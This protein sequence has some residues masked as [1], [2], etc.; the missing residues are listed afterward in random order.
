MSWVVWSE[1]EYLRGQSKG[2]DPAK[3]AVPNSSAF[4][5]QSDAASDSARIA[6]QM[7]TT[8]YSIREVAYYVCLS[9]KASWRQVGSGSETRLSERRESQKRPRNS[10]Q[11]CTSIAL[12]ARG[13]AGDVLRRCREAGTRQRAFRLWRVAAESKRCRRR[14][15]AQRAPPKLTHRSQSQILAAAF[16]AA[17]D[18]R[19]TIRL[20]AAGLSF[21]IRFKC[22]CRVGVPL[23]TPFLNRILNFVFQCIKFFRTRL[24]EKIQALRRDEQPKGH[25]LCSFFDVQSTDLPQRVAK[26]CGFRWPS[27]RTNATSRASA[28]DCTTRAHRAI[29]SVARRSAFPKR[30]HSRDA[31][32]EQ[33]HF[34]DL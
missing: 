29:R 15:A 22:C 30:V 31:H 3:R 32:T 27:L 11:Y 1:C 23:I 12:N 7:Q 18:I 16:F 28:V 26:R 2:S 14:R 25:T 33:F 8:K 21:P 17:F 24:L 19:A 34:S 10:V 4:A 5:E 6:R 9:R 20:V 13:A